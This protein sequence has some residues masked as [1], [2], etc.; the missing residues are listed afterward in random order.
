MFLNEFIKID[1][2]VARSVNIERD[3]SDLDQIKRFQLTP[4]VLDVLSRFADS[5][6]G[7]PISAWSLTGPYGSGKSAFCNYLFSLFSEDK[8][9]KST[10]WNSLNKTD[11]K[12]KVRLEKS[13]DKINI[14]NFINVRA[15]SQYEPLNKSLLRALLSTLKNINDKKLEELTTEIE[16]LLNQDSFETSLIVDS[17]DKISSALK[18]PFL[19]VIDEF[20]KNLEFMSHNPGKGDVFALQCLAESQNC[21]VFVCLHQSFNDYASN[22]S[23]I[24]LNEWGKVQGRFEDISYVEPPGRV[25]SLISKSVNIDEEKIDSKISKLIDSWCKKNANLINDLNIPNI[26]ELNHKDLWKIFP[27]NPIF[28][29]VLGELSKTFAQNQRTIFSFI[30]SGNPRALKKYLEI[31]KLDEKKKFEPLGLDWLYNYFCEETTQFHNNR[32]TTQKWIE[33]KNIINSFNASSPLEIKLLKTIGVLN[34]LGYLGIKASKNLIYACFESEDRQ[35]KIK[36]DKS[37]DN[38]ISSGALLYRSY[39]DEFRLWE[40]TDFDIEKAVIAEKSR[41]AVLNLSELLNL[42]LKR[43]NIIASRH[44]YQKG[45]IREFSQSWSEIGDIKKLEESNFDNLKFDGHIFLVVGKDN[46]EKDYLKKI[47]KEHPIIIG[48]L[49]FEALIKELALEA[50]ASKKVLETNPQLFNDGVARREVRFRVETSH[51]N[52]QKLINELLNSGNKK[53]Q[54]FALGEEKLN[55]SRFKI[56][57]FVSEVCDEVYSICPEVHM[58]MI[59]H[60]KLSPSA[61]RAQ[62]ELIEAMVTKEHI[63]NL[64]MEGFGPEV[65]F[66]RAMFKSLGLHKKIKKEQSFWQFVKPEKKDEKQKKLACVWDKINSTMEKA[67]KNNSPVLISELIKV[68]QKRPYG[69]RKG[70]IPLF[71]CHYILVNNDEIALYQEGIFKPVF[72]KAEAALL[73]KRPDLFSIKKITNTGFKKE[74]VQAY[75]SVLNTDLVNLNSSTRNKS[76][77][78]IVAPL[79]EFVKRLPDYTLYTRKISTKAQKL[80][81]VLLNSKEPLELLFKEIPQALNIEIIENEKINDDF[82]TKIFENLQTCLLELNTSFENLLVKIK[83]HFC[84][85][86]DKKDSETFDEFRNNIYKKYI[87]LVSPCKDLELKQILKAICTDKGD[88]NKWIM[89]VSG[90]IVEKPVDSWRDG[91]VD[92]YYA[93]L[94]E[95]SNRIKD[96]EVLL[97]NTFLSEFKKDENKFLLNL[98]QKNGSNIRK[99]FHLSEKDKLKVQENFSGINKLELSDIEKLIAFLIEDRILKNE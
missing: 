3:A 24:Q 68:F 99:V 33:I 90:L 31:S 15:L 70:V 89:G 1:S 97:S 46:D 10:A 44:S 48:F 43:Q 6:E 8:K 80:R 7:E 95:I 88:I 52:L 34:L 84:K 81:S 57:S 25:L 66:Y 35:L 14:E 54:W 87:K 47:T 85:C 53:V 22:L 72:N 39:S 93:Y 60:N 41:L 23:N 2:K 37:L 65:A 61:A 75:M 58:E 19:I 40:G 62:R 12:F 56:S 71:L 64:D 45:I 29:I 38:L 63:D 49:P 32:A 50:A 94:E 73:L 36:I 21:Y 30:S 69:L 28:G 17:I 16:N 83:E 76:L 55:N 74:I 4:V 11:K 51:N 77:L 78:K 92:V 18:R 67:E 9:V 26:P 59:N 82:K 20:G 91:D 86:F 5:L 27:I 79:V 42:N 13:L 96:F 98:T